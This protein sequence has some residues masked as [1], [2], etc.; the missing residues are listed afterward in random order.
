MSDDRSL[1]HD[2]VPL[3]RAQIKTLRH[4]ANHC[5]E[6]AGD[7]Y[8]AQIGAVL[9]S[10]MLGGFALELGLKLFYM[11]FHRKAVHGHELANL[12]GELPDQIRGD[13]SETYAGSIRNMSEIKY[14]GFI[15]S[16]HVPSPPAETQSASYGSAEEFFKAA[17]K[18]FVQSRYLFEEVGPNDWT[19]IP[20]PISYMTIM[21]NVLDVVYDEYLARG[22]WV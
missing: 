13:I 14:Y 5:E 16:A 22:T 17:S 3:M 12:F 15:T 4:M 2:R 19:I 8:S 10:N 1:N 21:S 11:T 9:V 20:H 18:I 7:P 6:G